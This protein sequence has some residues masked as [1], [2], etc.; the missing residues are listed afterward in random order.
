MLGEKRPVGFYTS[1]I[2]FST[3]RCDILIPL[4]L[5]VGV[6]VVRIIHCVLTMEY[7]HIPKGRKTTTLKRSDKKM[8]MDKTTC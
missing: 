3:H 4:Y 2:G 6:T 7:T 1:N 5:P 8:H